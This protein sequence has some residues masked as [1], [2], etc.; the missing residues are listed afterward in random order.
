MFHLDPSNTGLNKE[1][2]VVGCLILGINHP[3]SLSLCLLF[4]M[5]IHVVYELI[6]NS[7]MSFV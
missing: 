7:L 4:I 3:L 5:C 6:H 1:T 2:S